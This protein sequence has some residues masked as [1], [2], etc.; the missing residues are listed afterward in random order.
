MVFVVSSVVCS[1]YGGVF[2]KI[3]SILFGIIFVVIGITFAF[4]KNVDERLYR[5]VGEIIAISGII[6]LING[7][8]PAFDKHWFTGSMIAWFVIAGLDVL[9]IEKGGKRNEQEGK[10]YRN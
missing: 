6:F 9:Y 1:L 3:A 7:L 4:K 5:N 2:M 8:C 10:S